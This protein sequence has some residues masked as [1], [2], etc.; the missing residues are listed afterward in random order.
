MELGR[1]GSTS[2]PVCKYGKAR[3]CFNLGLHPC[4]GGTVFFQTDEST[5]SNPE[6][7]LSMDLGFKAFREPLRVSQMFIVCDANLLC[8]KAAWECG[9]SL[10]GR[11]IVW[12]SS[13]HAR[14]LS[15]THL[16]SLSTTLAAQ[17]QACYNNNPKHLEDFASASLTLLLC[18]KASSSA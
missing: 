5:H 15:L 7:A 3:A 4:W 17:R 10:T 6:F 16:Q 12:H 18:L 2:R 11:E 8:Q 14:Y 13:L 1:A 9:I